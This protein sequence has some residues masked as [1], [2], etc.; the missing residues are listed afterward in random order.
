[1]Y[2]NRCVAKTNAGKRCKRTRATTEGTCLQHIS[3]YPKRCMFASARFNRCTSVAPYGNDYCKEHK[4]L[5]TVDEPIVIDDS[6]DEI[7]TVHDSDSE[8]EYVDDESDD[9]EWLPYDH[10]KQKNP[11][12]VEGG[13]SESICDC[14]EFEDDTLGLNTAFYDYIEDEE[15]PN[16]MLVR[17]TIVA[18][19]DM[20]S[21]NFNKLLDYFEDIMS[22]RD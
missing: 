20:S 16:I 14:H 18:A 19:R 15:N 5:R 21:T 4:P 6:D 17:D 22:E 1:M 7:I 13:A 12:I 11:V 3:M 10:K 9:S 2:A 8:S